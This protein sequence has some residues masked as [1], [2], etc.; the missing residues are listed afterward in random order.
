VKSARRIAR[1]N[2]R[3]L[4][5]VLQDFSWADYGIPGAPWPTRRQL[6]IMRNETIRNARPD[7]ILWWAYHRIRFSDRP[8]PHWKDLLAAAFGP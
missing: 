8:E 4:T 1:S 2:R 3:R 7:L 6:R 5:V